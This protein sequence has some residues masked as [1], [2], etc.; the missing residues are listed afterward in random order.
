MLDGILGLFDGGYVAYDLMT[1]QYP[2]SRH[3]RDG[4]DTRSTT[5]STTPTTRYWTEYDLEQAAGQPNQ[6]SQV[7]L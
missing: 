3:V 5:V 1:V 4:N 2:I 7:P 6:T